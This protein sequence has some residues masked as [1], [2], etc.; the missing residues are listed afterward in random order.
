MA[1]ISSRNGI[2]ILTLFTAAVHLYLGLTLSVSCLTGVN[3]ATPRWAGEI[4]SDGWLTFPPQQLAVGFVRTDPAPVKGIAFPVADHPVR[5]VQTSPTCFRCSE[6]GKDLSRRVRI[7]S[8]PGAAPRR[9][10]RGRAARI[11][12]TL[13]TG[14]F[15][16]QRALEEE[17]T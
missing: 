2:T 10:A 4:K 16:W 13:K 9:A 3:A 5:A 7:A 6:G 14:L 1:F 17:R 15:F 8:P 12:P 11:A